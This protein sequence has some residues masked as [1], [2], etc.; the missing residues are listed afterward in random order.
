M[1]ICTSE[2]ADMYDA[3][4]DSCTKDVESARVE[5]PPANGCAESR[6]LGKATASVPPDCAKKYAK[7][8]M[9]KKE[10]KG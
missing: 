9:K 2:S 8:D 5:S 3:L 10:F 6:A 1:P 4:S 7:N